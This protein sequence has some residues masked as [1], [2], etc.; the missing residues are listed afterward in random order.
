MGGTPHLLDCVIRSCSQLGMLL[1]VGVAARGIGSVK[2]NGNGWTFDEAKGAVAADAG[3]C[4]DARRAVAEKDVAWC[5]RMESRTLTHPALDWLE[6]LEN[7]RAVHCSKT[8]GIFPPSSLPVSTSHLLD[9]LHLVNLNRCPLDVQSRKAGARRERTS[10][11]I[12]FFPSSS[13]TRMFCM[14]FCWYREACHWICLE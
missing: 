1:R 5:A 12:V 11:E 13:P 10:A 6:T 4:R 9:E 14:Y 2:N 7:S 8:R 3:G